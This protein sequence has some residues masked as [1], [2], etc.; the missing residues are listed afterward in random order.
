MKHRPRFSWY[1]QVS[2]PAQRAIEKLDPIG[3]SAIPDSTYR[4]RAKVEEHYSC[5]LLQPNVDVASSGLQRRSC[6]FHRAQDGIGPAPS[7]LRRKHRLFV[8]PPHFS[9][10]AACTARRKTGLAS[11]GSCS[12]HIRHSWASHS[13][14]Q[15]AQNH[16]PRPGP[17]EQG[18][19]PEAL[20]PRPP[21]AEQGPDDHRRVAV[22]RD[23]ERT[24]TEAIAPVR[25]R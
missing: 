9:G 18:P 5:E 11:T 3:A 8:Q 23:E 1:Q 4:T 25:H 10:P 22:F 7:G 15:H 19:A 21:Q 16:L 13:S 17:C 2:P 12:R 24:L 14:S 6:A 20:A